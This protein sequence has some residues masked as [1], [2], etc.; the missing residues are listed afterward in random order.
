VLRLV[1]S[2]GGKVGVVVKGVA[3]HVDIGVVVGQKVVLHFPVVG[4]LADG[5]FEILLCDGIPE[6]QISQ[7]EK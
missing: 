2:A 1:V 5:E 3:S 6:L 7:Y 4:P